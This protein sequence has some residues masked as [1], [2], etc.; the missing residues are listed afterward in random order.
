MREGTVESS[1]RPLRRHV[2]RP[3]GV[4]IGESVADTYKP[5]LSEA[6]PDQKEPTVAEAKP[7]DQMTRRELQQVVAALHVYADQVDKMKEGAR[8]ALLPKLL[9]FAEAEG[10]SGAD[11]RIPGIDLPS[12]KPLAKITL[13]TADESIAVTD[14]RAFTLWVEDYYPDA[15]DT[16]ITVRPE[17]QS[18]ILENLTVQDGKAY[19]I[20]RET[21]EYADTD[22][23]GAPVPVPGVKVRPAKQSSQ[24]TQFSMRFTRATKESDPKAMILDAILTGRIGDLLEGITAAPPRPE[25][26]P[27]TADVVDAEI[28]DEVA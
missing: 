19:R 20:D 25:L 24:A 7:F 10:A 4:C 15:V 26:E 22:D 5:H 13:P 14:K 17:V 28:V 1:W 27:G 21:G 3:Y 11:V 23:T 9:E 18:A 2:S 6:G 12:G 16:I 8:A